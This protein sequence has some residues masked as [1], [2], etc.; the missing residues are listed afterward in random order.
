MGT[1]SF[2][3]A[4][5]IWLASCSA[6]FAPKVPRDKIPQ[7]R[8]IEGRLPGKDWRESRPQYGEIQHFEHR[9]DPSTSIRLYWNPATDATYAERL[10]SSPALSTATIREN[11]TEILGGKSWQRVS[12]AFPNRVVMRLYIAIFE[13]ATLHVQLTTNDE[14]KLAI[15]AG[16]LRNYVE[17]LTMRGEPVE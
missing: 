10:L 12:I 9:Y 3:F 4:S 6:P 1:K 17:N 11:T 5:V 15:H 7:Q 14:T 16:S 13:D 2:L 8:S